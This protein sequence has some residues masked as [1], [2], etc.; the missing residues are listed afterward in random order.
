MDKQIAIEVHGLLDDARQSLEKSVG[1]VRAQL[2][3][4]EFHKYCVVVG[5]VLA[6]LQLE[7]LAPFI[8]AEHPDLEPPPPKHD[9]TYQ[10]LMT[11]LGPRF[12][13]AAARARRNDNES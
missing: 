12:K 7:L 8:Y 9:P 10:E 5:T 13:E 2:S 4:D 1:V 3:K 6:D 11:R